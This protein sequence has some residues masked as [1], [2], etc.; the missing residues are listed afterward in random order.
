MKMNIKDKL[1]MEQIRELQNQIA[2]NLHQLGFRG[3][4]DDIGNLAHHLAELSVFGKKLSADVLPSLLTQPAK[5]E[6]E[7]GDMVVDLNYE[8]IEMKQAIEDMEP[9]LIRLMNFLTAR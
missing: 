9:A 4:E 3:E 7:L 2:K 1:E 5:G 6:Q 8:L